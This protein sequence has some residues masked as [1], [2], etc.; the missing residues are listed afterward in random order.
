MRADVDFGMSHFYTF[1]EDILNIRRCLISAIFILMVVLFA[2]NCAKAAN[3]E[4]V[5]DIVVLV[6]SGVLPTPYDA[7]SVTYNG[8]TS[9]DQAHADL[10]T[11]STLGGWQAKASQI[12]TVGGT[13]GS[14]FQALGVV[15]WNLGVLPIEPFVRT[16]KRYKNI[17]LHFI[18]KGAFPFKSLRNYSDKYVDI[19][20]SSTYEA[21]IYTIKIK[22]PNFDKLNLPIMVVPETQKNSPANTEQPAKKSG[23]AKWLI[24]LAAGIAVGIIAFVVVNRINQLR[25]E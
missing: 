13:T 25:K 22:N 14:E 1:Q 16:F 9:K 7:V 4:P 24:A 2:S 17:K 15:K 19:S 11:L 3:P 10:K 21:Y 23:I 20:F 5:P 8:K 18:V 12:S 6:L